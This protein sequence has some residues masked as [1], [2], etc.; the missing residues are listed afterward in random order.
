MGFFKNLDDS[1][2]F[3]GMLGSFFLDSWW[4][5]KDSLALKKIKILG[6]FLKDS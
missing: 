6:G 2:R 3:S 4:L 5:L 1:S